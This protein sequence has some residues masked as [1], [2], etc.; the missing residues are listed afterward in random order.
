MNGKKELGGSRKGSPLEDEDCYPL[1]LDEYLTIKE[2]STLNK[3]TNLESFLLTTFIA[4][5]ISGVVIA[6]TSS[7]YETEMIEGV[8]K[9]TIIFAHVI[10]IIVYGSIILGSLIAFIII[11]LTKKK[12]KKSIERLDNKI[13]KHLEEIK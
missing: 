3:F 6:F 8:S 11:R 1:T 7:F 10:I 4:S 12:T 13:L 2:N 5:L 9:E